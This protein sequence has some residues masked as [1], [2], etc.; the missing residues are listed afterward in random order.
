MSTCLARWLHGRQQ[1]QNQ[2]GGASRCLRFLNG[3]SIA[4]AYYYKQTERMKDTAKKKNE[5]T[6]KLPSLP[7]LKEHRR[8]T[9]LKII[10][11]DK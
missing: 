11:L 9:V 4:R 7:T 8:P 5:N 6:R 3:L 10:F 2:M 1:Q